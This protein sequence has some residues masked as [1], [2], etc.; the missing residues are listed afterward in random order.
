MT[1]WKYYK[2]AKIITFLLSVLLTYVPLAVMV[3]AGFTGNTG[4]EKAVLIACVLGAVILAII[5]SKTHHRIKG[6]FSLI[7]LG[8]YLTVESIGGYLLAIMICSVLDDI[9]MDPLHCYYKEEFKKIDQAKAVKEYG[10]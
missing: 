6:V 9:L 5:E 1:A 4:T 7:T 8:C 10:Q 3:I 2:K